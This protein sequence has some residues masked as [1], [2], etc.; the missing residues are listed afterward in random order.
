MSTIAD[1]ANAIKPKGSALVKQG[2]L[3]V[4]GVKVTDPEHQLNYSNMLLKNRYSL[5]CLGKRRYYLV[6]WRD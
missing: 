2:A 3:K 6:D 4:N 1:L 5:I